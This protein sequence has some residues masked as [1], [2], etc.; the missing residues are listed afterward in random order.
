MSNQISM[1]IEWVSVLIDRD[2]FLREVFWERGGVHG[3]YY[4]NNFRE[5]WAC[6]ASPFPG[7]G[8]AIRGFQRNTEFEQKPVIL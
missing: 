1:R 2:R 7:T 5:P 4:P 3:L 8:A 6:K